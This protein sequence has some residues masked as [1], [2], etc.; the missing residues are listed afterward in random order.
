M[1]G[2]HC[3]VKF[4][5]I[6]VLQ[7]IYPNKNNKNRFVIFFIFDIK[8]KYLF[9]VFIKKINIRD[10]VFIKNIKNKYSFLRYLPLE[11][12]DEIS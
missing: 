7:Y 11:I 12:V 9:I 10:F 6:F 4:C 5:L 3:R 2:W 8:A 1:Q